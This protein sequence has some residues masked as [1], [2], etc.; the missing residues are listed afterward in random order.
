MPRG[1]G[2]MI[3]FMIAASQ[4]K[5][6]ADEFYK[7]VQADDFQKLKAF[8]HNRGY[9]YVDDPTISIILVNKDLYKGN[10]TISPTVV[11]QY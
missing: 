2:G 4:D 10:Q 3:D 1:A 8:L 5:N 6:L 9:V 7:T 11:P